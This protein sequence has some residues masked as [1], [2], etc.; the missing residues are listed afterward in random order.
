LISHN[1]N[2]L[3]RVCHNPDSHQLLSVVATVH[4]QGVGQSLDNRAL[5]LSESLCGISTGG[6]RSVDGGADLDVVATGVLSAS[7]STLSHGFLP[8]VKEMSRTSTSS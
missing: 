5:G 6:V 8:Y 3:K 4:H 1:V 2:D 7:C